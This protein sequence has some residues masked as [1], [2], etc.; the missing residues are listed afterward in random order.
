M[1]ALAIQNEQDKTVAITAKL[2]FYGNE[3][4]DEL[5]QKIVQEIREMY[6][7]PQALVTL[8]GENF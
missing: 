4:T 8:G 5:T 2:I 1:S 6:H 3:A 7:Q